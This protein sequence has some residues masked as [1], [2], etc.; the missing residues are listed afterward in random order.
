MCRECCS[1]TFVM[2]LIVFV[3]LILVSNSFDPAKFTLK[4]DGYQFEAVNGVELLSVFFNVRALIPCTTLCF[5]NIQCRTF[6]FDSNSKQCRLFEGSVDTGNILSTVSTSTV[7]WVN[8]NSS[9][10]S[11]YNASNDQCVNNRFLDSETLSGRCDCPIHT[12]WNGSICLNQRFVNDT[13]QNDSWCRTDLWI[14]CLASKC[15][16]KTCLLDSQERKEEIHTVKS[17]K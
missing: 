15:V 1:F 10:F 13:C 16:G 12:F 6:A 14:K 9:M 7:G 8:L 2:K 4:K 17:F 5:S 3:C 11:S